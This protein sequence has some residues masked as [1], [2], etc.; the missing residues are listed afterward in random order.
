MTGRMLRRQVISTLSSP[1]GYF[2][3]L[4]LC[5]RHNGIRHKLTPSHSSGTSWRGWPGVARFSNRPVSG[6]VWLLGLESNLEVSEKNL[7]Q[8]SGGN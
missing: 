6:L 1:V 2:N 4:C 3:T 8:L 5:K 7:E